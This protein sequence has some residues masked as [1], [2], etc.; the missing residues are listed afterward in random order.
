MYLNKNNKTLK[1]FELPV[2]AVMQANVAAIG[3]VCYITH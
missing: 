3:F 1:L 2:D